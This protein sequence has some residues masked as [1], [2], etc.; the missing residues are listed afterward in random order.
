MHAMRIHAT[1]PAHE[2]GGTLAT[3]HRIH[4]VAEKTHIVVKD[5]HYCCRAFLLASYALM[6]SGT[7][8]K[9]GRE[10]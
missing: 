3:S 7:N 9:Q 10:P 1:E 5:E 2:S 8:G 4:D 6:R